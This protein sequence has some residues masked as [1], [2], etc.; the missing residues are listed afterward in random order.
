MV[1]FRK[2]KILYF[3]ILDEKLELIKKVEEFLGPRNWIEEWKIREN[4]KTENRRKLE[5]EL[6]DTVKS[7]KWEECSEMMKNGVSFDFVR[8]DGYG[9]FCWLLSR[10]ID[11]NISGAKEILNLIEENE[12]RTN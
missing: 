12:N 5:K 8:S 2:F 6:F 7:K 10:A 11:D 9:T 4:G 3:K 1:F